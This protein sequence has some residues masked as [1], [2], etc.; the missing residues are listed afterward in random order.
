M[1]HLFAVLVCLSVGA[2]SGPISGT[3]RAQPVPTLHIPPPIVL[4]VGLLE[5]RFDTA[6]AADCSTDRCF[7]KGCVYA[8]H[9]TIDLPRQTSLPGLPSDEGPGAVAPQEYLTEARCEFTHEK[10]VSTRD[11]Q[12]LARRLEQR[13]SKGWLK[14][15][16]SPQ[17]LEPVSKALAE[18]LPETEKP[19]EPEPE[20]PP[21]TDPDSRKGPE[22]APVPEP[23]WNA[24]VAVHEL[25]S[26]LLPHIPWML[27]IFL[28]TVAT[29]V[30]IWA[31]RRLGTP[32][33]EEKMLEAQMAQAPAPPPPEPAPDAE[34]KTSEQDADHDFA[35][36]QQRVWS[37]RV[38]QLQASEPNMV[39]DLV[40]E[41]LKVG[42]FPTLARAL[43]TFGDRLSLAFSADADLA[44]KKLE[45]A[46][47][48]RDVDESTL[49]T[50]AQFF[51]RLNQQSMSSLLMSQADVQLY[52]ALRE[53]FG[54]AG[55]CSLMEQLP[56][57]FSA[58]LFAIVPRDAQIDV[59]RLL[60][61]EVRLS[62]ASQL[63]VSTRISKEES[64]FVFA[65]VG[66]AME[67]KALPP[68]PKSAITD[69]GPAVDAPTAL[70]VLLPHIP[71]ADR[72]AL[73]V[74]ALQQSGGNAPA[75]FEDIFFGEMLTQLDSELRSDLL[76]DVD[77]RG[78]S[79]WL[80]MQEQ[81]WRQTFVGQLS[82][83]MQNALRQNAS[84]SSRAEQMQLGRRGHQD[85]V[86]ALKGLYA[87]DRTGF[88]KLVA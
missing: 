34:K 75:W 50:R 15:T 57:R 28:L 1:R 49:P 32:S 11:V 64:A 12:A 48:F 2:V 72:S 70:S 46:E 40:R 18:P 22:P 38:A 45:F 59:A 44:L 14:V 71:G 31:A 65:C 6:L 39:G 69:R 20:T 80:S 8:R 17:L 63:L 7:S 73:L 47:Y 84:F 87:R 5:R 35:E 33:L 23:T 58:L 67:G 74:S 53:D 3:A 85:L 27:A 21:A 51:R 66:A 77:I 68:P 60:S 82:P 78:L 13:L 29:A 36:E 79:A 55:I 56:S 4:E 61:P 37:E 16:V 42:E 54:S 86:R 25:W 43:L 10:S 88:L 76:L 19:P 30:L 24:A 9:Q 41:W 26:S 83:S 52:R 62:V 81:S